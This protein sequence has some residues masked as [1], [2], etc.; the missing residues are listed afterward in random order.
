MAV[1]VDKCVNY[2]WRWGKSCHMVADSF[3]ELHAMGAAIGLNR[4]WFQEKHRDPHYDLTVRKR[5]AAV[6]LGAVE[7]PRKAFV[8][9]LVELRGK[10]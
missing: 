3:E 2:G 6:R 4:T 7:L 1:Y 9:K 8:E 5:A 10:R